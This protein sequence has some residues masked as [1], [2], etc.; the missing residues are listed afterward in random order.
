MKRRPKSLEKVSG[1]REKIVRMR[2]TI[3]FR[4]TGDKD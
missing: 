2:Y 4:K 1:F 3:C